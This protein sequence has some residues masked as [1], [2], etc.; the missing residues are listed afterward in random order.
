M[1]EVSKP[2]INQARYLLNFREPQKSVRLD[3][4]EAELAFGGMVAGQSQQ[5]NVPDSAD[6]N[7]ARIVFASGKKNL[8]ISQLAV[9]LTLSFDATL[10]V[11][12]QMAIVEKNVRD[13]HHRVPQ[14]KE[15]S[16][17]AA[18]AL[19]LHINFPSTE[20]SGRL[21]EFLYEKLIKQAPV[22]E[23]ASVQTNLGFKFGEIFANIGASIYESRRFSATFEPGVNPLMQTFDLTSLPVIESGLQITLDINNRPRQ[24]ANPNVVAQEPDPLIDV[25]QDMLSQHMPK[26]IGLNV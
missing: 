6:P 26:L 15:L 7:I 12:K 2:Y 21:N 8:T 13:F 4:R 22:G 3:Q 1:I 24:L 23:I 25:I 18:N 20:T 17:F 16:T 19:I 14:F 9:Q 11:A 5:L 10:D